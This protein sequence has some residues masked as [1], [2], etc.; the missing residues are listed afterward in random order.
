VKMM[1]AYPE[2]PDQLSLLAAR[3]AALELRVDALEHLPQSNVVRM[4]EVA[5]AAK[6]ANPVAQ[7][8]PETGTATAFTG[9]FSVLGAALLGIAGA[10]ALRAVSGANLLPRA[11]VAGLAAV[12][13]IAWLLAAAHA[14]LRRL[15][16]SLYAATSV[17]T[18]APMLWETSIRFRAMTA[19]G[20]AGVL[21]AYT[22]IAIVIGFRSARSAAFLVACSG[23]ALTAVA[24]AIG[25]H[26]LAL[27]AAILLALHGICELTP[28]REHASGIRALVSLSADFSA[29]TLILVYPLTPGEQ[30]VYPPL[31]G[32]AILSAVLLLFAVQ[33]ASLV[34]NAVQSLQPMG[35]FQTL[36]VM[37]AFIL[38]VS[39]VARFIPAFGAHA[40]ALLCLVI[41]GAAYASAYGTFR[42]T[43]PLRNF[44]I[45]SVWS[46]ALLIAAVFLL[47][48][49]TLASAILGAVAL[50]AIPLAA[51]M[52]ARSIEVQ[53][54]I[55]LCIA[56]Y[57]SG[58]LSYALHALLGKMPGAPSWPVILV[59]VCALLAY[60]ATDEV[61][62]EPAFKQALDLVPALLATCGL[63]A[64]LVRGFVA[65]ASV[66][67]TL[68]VF[69]VAVLR[70]LTLCVIALA[71]AWFGARLGRVQMVRVAYAALA[72][73]SAKLLFEDLRHGRM[74]FIAASI[75]FV[76][77][78]FIEVPR[79]ARMIYSG[80]PGVSR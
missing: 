44:Y 74:E 57:A 9:A 27:F 35:A 40:I 8:V 37:I 64:F 16:A 29:L 6:R 63:T 41:A 62:H 71:L 33:V 78:T 60:A 36:Q 38:L 80:K 24:L 52:R 31:G 23:S 66:A 46:C 3:V 13:A 42:R 68:E 73:A 76:A 18:L 32:A 25:T 2:A 14:D 51:R 11:L 19:T 34:M 10:Y 1:N 45:F 50:V 43:V 22:A 7:A 5:R 55:F 65:L 67:L 75:F 21:C 72:L 17:L 48:S 12:Y 79:L 61:P 39:A 47:A 69:H 30:S 20:A 59:A 54:V 56:A 58:L 26:H 4:E 49:P 53:G 70:T 77:L 15:A 28:L